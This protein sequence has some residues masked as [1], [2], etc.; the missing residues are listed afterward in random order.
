LAWQVP[1]V[2]MPGAFD[3]EELEEAYRQFL[4]KTVSDVAPAPVSQ[5]CAASARC[6]VIW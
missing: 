5:Q 6:P 1:F 3:R 2:S 4:I